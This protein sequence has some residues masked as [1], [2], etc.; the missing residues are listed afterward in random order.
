M[1]SAVPKISLVTPSLNQ[2][3]FIRATIES[4]LTQGYPNLDYRVQ[5]G[6]STDETLAVLRAREPLFR[7]ARAS[8]LETAGRVVSPYL[9]KP[10]AIARL[11]DPCLI[12]QPAAS[13]R[14]K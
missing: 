13:F 12:A 7:W 2:G 1:K 4:V 6:G 9:V 3:K 14:R 10:A 8:C 5:D 11:A